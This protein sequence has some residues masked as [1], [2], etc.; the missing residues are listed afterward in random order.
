MYRLNSSIGKI[1][2]YSLS[3][4][5]VIMGVLRK[6][7]T[8]EYR[9]LNASITSDRKGN[10]TQVRYSIEPEEGCLSHRFSEIELI[11]GFEK[12]I[13]RTL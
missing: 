1:V 4:D 13:L 12:G 6:C 7:N 3:N 8:S 10:P 2:E 9:E 11:E 5:L